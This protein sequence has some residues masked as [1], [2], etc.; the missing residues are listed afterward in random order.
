MLYNAANCSA[1]EIVEILLSTAPFTV[2]AKNEVLHVQTKYVH[3]A[4]LRTLLA[5]YSMGRQ[6]CF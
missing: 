2:D 5:W 4:Y 6:P 3:T 1:W